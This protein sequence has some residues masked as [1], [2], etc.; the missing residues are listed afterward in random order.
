MQPLRSG[1]KPPAPRLVYAVKHESN[2]MID[3]FTGKPVV[4]DYYMGEAGGMGE[5]AKQMNLP[6]PAP[7]EKSL[8]P[9]EQQEVEKS[10]GLITQG[11]AVEAVKKWVKIP[12]NMELRS[13]GLEK[14][15]KNSGLRTWNLN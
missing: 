11:Q 7:D 10:A 8:S 14:N 13:A 15:W 2:A 3:A 9:E 12:D 6:A 1:Q 4:A 5:S